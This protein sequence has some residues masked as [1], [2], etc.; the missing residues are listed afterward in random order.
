M[1]KK[2]QAQMAVQKILHID[3]TVAHLQSQ[4]KF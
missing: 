2:K 3:S 4:V 1:D